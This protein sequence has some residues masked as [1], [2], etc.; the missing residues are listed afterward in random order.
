MI[1]YTAKQ[2]GCGDLINFAGSE[3]EPTPLYVGFSL[4]EKELEY[5]E[6]LQKALKI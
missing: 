1:D 6:K 2:N 3:G 5:A 4:N